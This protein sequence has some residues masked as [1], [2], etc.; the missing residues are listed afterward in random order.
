MVEKWKEQIKKETL[1]LFRA[2]PQTIATIIT[3]EICK[4]L[5]F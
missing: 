5:L 2:M 3:W 4:Y 1:T